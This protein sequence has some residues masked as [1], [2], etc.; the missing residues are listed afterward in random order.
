MLPPEGWPFE[1]RLSRRMCTVRT[2]NCNCACEPFSCGAG[3][4]GAGLAGVHAAVVGC[5]SSGDGAGPNACKELREFVVLRPHK[6]AS[7]EE[8]RA[9]CARRLPRA[10]VPVRVEVMAQ[11]PRTR[12]GKLLRRE[13][14]RV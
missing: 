6:Q 11:L 3:A 14:G 8:V 4:G 2:A 1:A 5:P 12:P 9:F 13:L 7:G 10:M